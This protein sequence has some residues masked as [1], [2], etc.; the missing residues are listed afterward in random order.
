MDQNSKLRKKIRLQRRALNS[1]QQKKIE[2]QCF[3][4]FLRHPTFLRSR[5][6]GI[7]LDAFGE[8]KTTK[9]IE[10]CFDHHKSV[11]LPM[12]CNM[13]NQLMWVKISRQ[14]Y[15]NKR[16][17]YHQLGMYEPMTSRGMHISKLDLVIMPLLACDDRGTRMGMGGG[18]YDRTL[19]TAPHSPYRLGL[20]HD[21]QLL[22][23]KLNR[24]IWDQPLDSLITPSKILYFKRQMS[25]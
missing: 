2:Q 1:F 24:N 25:Q 3:R 7:Y 12:I 15:R 19:A 16:F 14:Q 23:E 13:N 5:M 22:N 6:I 18:F 4:Q 17:S 10:Y 21:F 20:G 11:Y 9:I 8:V